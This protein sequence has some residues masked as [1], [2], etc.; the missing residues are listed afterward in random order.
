[1]PKKLRKFTNSEFI[2]IIEKTH[3]LQNNRNQAKTSKIS[4]N[5]TCVLTSP[6]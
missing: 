2:V 5:T 4:H 1:M 3:H 6:S